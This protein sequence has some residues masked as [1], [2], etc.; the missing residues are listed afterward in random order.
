MNF[1]II[2]QLRRFVSKVFDLTHF[3]RSP[4]IYGASPFSSP[5][6]QYQKNCQNYHQFAKTHRSISHRRS[7]LTVLEIKLSVTETLW[8]IL[9]PMFV[10]RFSDFFTGRNVISRF[11]DRCLRQV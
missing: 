4:K 2:K 11:T 7:V 8:M 6:Y 5:R 9:D 3:D 1:K 10:L